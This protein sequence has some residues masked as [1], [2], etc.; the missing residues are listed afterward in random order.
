MSTVLTILAALA[1][2]AGFLAQLARWLRVLQREH[3][4]AAAPRRFFVRWTSPPIASARSVERHRGRAPVTPSHV[5]MV[6]VLVAV[7]AR[8]DQVAAVV[9]G[10]YGLTCPW[11][12]GLRGRTGKLVWTLRLK[13]VALVAAA[14]GVA[15]A[16]ASLLGPRP[17]L[18][19]MAVVWATP[20]LVGW[21]ASW[22]RPLEERRAQR[23]VDQARRRLDEVAPRV[24]GI[25]GSYGKTSTKNHLAD[26]LA[27]DGGVVAT[28]RSF[29]NRGGLSRSVNEGL[30]DDTRVFIAEMGT[31][32]PGEIA[33]LCD[34]CPPEI[35][36]VT[37]IGPVHLERMG[38]L[39]VIDRAKFEI[40]GRAA[41]V[42]LNVDDERLARWVERL[43]GA[44]KRVVTAGSRGGDVEVRVAVSDGTW[45][46]EVDGRELARTGALSG[47]QPTN[48][49]CALGAARAL[50][51]PVEVLARRWTEVRAVENR[52]RVATAPSGV[53]VI[54]DTFNANPASA[55]AALVLLSTL[56]T[57]GRR[58]VVTP[59][60]V[61]LG[62]E[63]FSENRELGARA[64]AIGAELVVVGRTNARAL[65][66]GF[67]ERATRVD[68]R[69]EAVAWVRSNL[70]AGDAVL[71]LNDLPDH[72][73]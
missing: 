31:Y 68:R 46:L 40:T 1:L 67:G 43:E 36:V 14:V 69:D 30:G 21:S 19:A 35:A 51:V 47:V 70:A 18:G 3:Y 26:L 20:L 33:A 16:A 62:V 4:E 10:V 65:L 29:N 9:T 17:L 8:A 28:P 5:A 73:P 50:G 45:I 72:Y 58:V 7:V 32:G 54:D 71:Y 12:L 22:V 27:P 57:T 55:T 41:T 25:T 48:L 49:A 64:R 56:G 24:I 59:G 11:G 23:F 63:A 60:M 53:V 42:V 52:S 66:E 61:E 44:G 39:D 13:T 15:V 38:S 34:W 37:A 6:L 2:A